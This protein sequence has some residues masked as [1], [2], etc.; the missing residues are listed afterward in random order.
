METEKPKLPESCRRELALLA[1]LGIQDPR[2]KIVF[3]AVKSI[4]LFDGVSQ[5]Q[6]W[7]SK[8]RL[9]S[10]EISAA[11]EIRNELQAVE[12]CDPVNALQELHRLRLQHPALIFGNDIRAPACTTRPKS[13]RQFKGG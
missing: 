13:F 5:L 4:E 12:L 2:R 6:E 8:R 10:L 7:D 1:P 11:D 9:D 3:T